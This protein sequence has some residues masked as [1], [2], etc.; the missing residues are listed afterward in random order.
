VAAT[1]QNKEVVVTWTTAYESGS[2][3]F[4]VERSLDGGRTFTGL[5]RVT[6]AGEATERT[7]YAFTDNSPVNGESAYR[8]RQAD[9]N[10]TVDYSNVVTVT[11][12]EPSIGMLSPNPTNGWLRLRGIGEAPLQA[13]VLDLE[14]RT[15]LR[16]QLGSGGGFSV[17]EL[18]TGVYLLR[19]TL[20]REVVTRRFVKR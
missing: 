6:A 9:V 5:G 15:L 19:Y 13:S 7:D 14:G 18:P 3:Y 10:E 1:P 16:K 11:F 17:T 4:E 12:G 2:D 8:I 20:D